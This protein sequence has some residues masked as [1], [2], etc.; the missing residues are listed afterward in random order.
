MSQQPPPPPPPG[1]PYFAPQVARPKA[2]FDPLGIGIVV[3]G[4]LALVFSLITTFYTVS[5]TASANGQHYSDSAGVNA[6]HGFFGWVGALLA[7]VAAVYVVL[8]AFGVYPPNVPAP[9][10]TAGILGLSF[11]CELVALFVIPQAGGGVDEARKMGIDVDF[12]HGWNYWAVFILV[13]VALVLA[14]LR[15]AKA[16]KG[17]VTR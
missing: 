16:P 5:V 7:L 13:I 17:Q 3:A 10:A 1:Q 9:L 11:I 8:A 12:G 2:G 15:M 4:V 14:V 6:W